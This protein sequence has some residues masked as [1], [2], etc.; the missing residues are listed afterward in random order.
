MQTGRDINN[1][2]YSN[3]S[4]KITILEMVDTF[5]AMHCTSYKYSKAD[6]FWLRIHIVLWTRDINNMLDYVSVWTDEFE[7]ITTTDHEQLMNEDHYLFEVPEQK[8]SCLTL[9]YQALK[10]MLVVLTVPLS[11]QSKLMVNFP[12]Q[13]VVLVPQPLLLTYTEYLV[14]CTRCNFYFIRIIFHRIL[15]CYI[16]KKK[17]IDIALKIIF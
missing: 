11:G 1:S 4:T 13:H 12:I 15:L 10:Y 8:L 6:I 2:Q 17:L 16:C 5:H 7:K 14:F 3:L 9:P